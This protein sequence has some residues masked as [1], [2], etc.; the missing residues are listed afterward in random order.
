MDH[1][2]LNDAERKQILT[3]LRANAQDNKVLLMD[4]KTTRFIG[5]A[6]EVPDDEVITAIKSVPVHYG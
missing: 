6:D 5:S 3:A 1:R 4:R 2:T